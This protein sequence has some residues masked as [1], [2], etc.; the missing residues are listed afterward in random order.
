MALINRIRKLDL[1]TLV[2]A[3]AALA[4]AFHPVQWL[5]RT[6]THPAFDSDGGLVFAAVLALGVWSVAS[7][8]ATRDPGTSRR[9]L[10]LLTLTALVRGV[11]ELLA[12]D[13]IGGIALTVDVVALGL[14]LGLRRRPWAVSPMWL[15][16]LFLFSL[17]VERILQRVVGFPLQS[18]AARGA[19]TLLS[20]RGGDLVCA[21][22][23]ITLDGQDVLVDLPCAGTQSLFILGAMFC[24][25]AARKRPGLRMAI[26]GA[27]VTLAGALVGNAV[28]IAVIAVGIVDGGVI[29]SVGA[30]FEHGAAH[31]ITGLATLALGVLPIVAWAGRVTEPAAGPAPAPTPVA[32]TAPGAHPQRARQS[33]PPRWLALALGPVALFALAVPAAPLDVSEEFPELALPST[34]A[35]HP[36]LASP[37]TDSET[38]AYAEHGGTAMRA[39]YGSH[40]VLAV[41]TSSPLRHLHAPDECLRGLGADVQRL[42]VSW[43]PYPA[44]VYRVRDADGQQWRVRVTFIG[45]DGTVATSVAEV[46]WRW[47]RAPSTTWTAL[48]HIA[49]WGTPDHA[50]DRVARLLAAAFEL[51]VPDT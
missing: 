17:P 24:A 7:G 43:A 5:V 45:S 11:G 2:V 39:T 3:V 18:I 36:A 9:A 37:L 48:Q 13:A 27:L 14:L 38:R 22:T 4:L 46:V 6:W 29:A 10:L 41:R 33:R 35:G 34:L 31:Q 16:A 25:F 8:P 49:P 19:C 30:S 50:S 26:T 44:A 20:G 1:A 15:G 12:I 21:G 42:G 28:R 47:L 40:T 23:R 32:G 51:P